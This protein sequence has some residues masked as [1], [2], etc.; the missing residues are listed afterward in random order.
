MDLQ[1]AISEVSTGKIITEAVVKQGKDSIAKFLG[2]ILQEGEKLSTWFEKNAEFERGKKTY[3]Q[4]KMTEDSSLIKH[5]TI[6]RDTPIWT[7]F[8]GRIRGKG[9]IRDLIANHP[10][11]GKTVVLKIE[12]TKKSDSEVEAFNLFFGI[13]KEVEIPQEKQEA[14]AKVAVLYGETK[15]ITTQTIECPY[16][17][18][19]MQVD[20]VDVV[21]PAQHQKRITVSE[22]TQKIP[23][24]KEQEAPDKK[25][26]SSAQDKPPEHICQKCG[27]KF[28]ECGYA[29]ATDGTGQQSCTGLKEKKP[30]KKGKKGDK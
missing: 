24:K 27:E 23:F 16:C 30:E 7:A 17:H 26:E 13:P 4:Y 2:K 20:V 6:E 1:I 15:P 25:Q 22:T 19:A 5:F 18:S 8:L 12:M 21:V 28:P 9:L 11:D 29:W 14:S 3:V 10:L